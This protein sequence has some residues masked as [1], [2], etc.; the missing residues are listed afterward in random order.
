MAIASGIYN[1]HGAASRALKALPAN[2]RKNKPWIRNI[3]LLQE[4]IGN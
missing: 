1:D 2:I 4:I 3:G